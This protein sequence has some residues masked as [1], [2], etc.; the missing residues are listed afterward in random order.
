[1]ESLNS[2]TSLVDSSPFAIY[3]LSIDDLEVAK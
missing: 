3:F 1:M 2:D